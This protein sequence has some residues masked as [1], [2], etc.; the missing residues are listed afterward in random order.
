MVGP[1]SRLLADGRD[2]KQALKEEGEKFVQRLTARGCLV[3][4][5]PEFYRTANDD[6]LLAIVYCEA[7]KHG[8]G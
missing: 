2:Q 8:L 6:W 7:G 3:V 5:D 4:S 1:L